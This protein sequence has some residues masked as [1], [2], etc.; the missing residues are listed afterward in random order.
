M[1]KSGVWSLK[2]GVKA[3]C[4]WTPDSRLQTPD[5]PSVLVLFFVVEEVV[6]VQVFLDDVELDGVE[7]DDL[8]RR[9]T[10]V[11]GDGVAFVGVEADVDFGFAVRAR[12]YRHFPFL[13]V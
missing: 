1:K 8:K 3:A 11:A 2:S 13:Q 5:L 12:S 6:L 9:P 7:P 10:L 4:F